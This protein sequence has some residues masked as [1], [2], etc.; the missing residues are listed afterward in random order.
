M[1]ASGGLAL[2]WAVPVPPKLIGNGVSKARFW[3]IS[4]T[5]ITQI[6]RN[7]EDNEVLS[8]LSTDR[9]ASEL[10]LYSLFRK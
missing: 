10:R 4:R 1:F 2:S 5:T 7:N 6:I 9:L 3:D 8:I